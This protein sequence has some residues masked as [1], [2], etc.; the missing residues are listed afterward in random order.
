MK[1][2]QR[3]KNVE[4]LD[5]KNAKA[6]AEYEA[7]NE[8]CPK[9]NFAQSVKWGRVKKEWKFYG[10]ISRDEKG[11]ICGILSLLVRK[12][13]AL[14]TS[15]M[16]AP[17]GPVCDVHDK[18]VLSDLLAGA[19]QIAKECK[20][21]IIKMD[22]DVKSEDTEFVSIM[23]EI[24]FSMPRETK[25]FEGVQPRYVFRL[26]L[27]GRDDEQLMESYHSKTRYNIRLAIKKGVEVKRADKSAL[28]DFTRIMKTTG[29]RDNFITRGQGYFERIMDEMGENARLYMAYLDGKAIAGTLAIGYGDKVWYLY[30]A[31]S[32]EFRNV[33][34]NYLLQAA[35]IHWA[36]ERGARIYD[37]RGVSGDTS[38]DNPLYGLYRFKKGFNGEFTEFVG[39][40]NMVLRPLMKQM[41]DVAQKCFKKYNRIKYNL[42]KR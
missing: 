1:C 34:P 38:P 18:A 41:V 27:E 35:M 14:P 15:L 11:E 3:R 2:A 19:K 24:G 7:F 12:I 31:S 33:M 5:L 32:N 10:V 8:K 21:Y 25:N 22:T 23:Q 29:E 16:Y 9:G 17:R 26:P 4:F 42:K 30:G 36:V 40:M 37:F 6:V 13:P 39:E 20:S 28:G